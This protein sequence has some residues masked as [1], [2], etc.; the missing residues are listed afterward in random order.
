MSITVRRRGMP[1]R[2]PEAQLHLW[3]LISPALPIG[4]YAYS[5]GLE[6]AVE[7]GWVRNEADTEDWILGQ[8]QHGL[9]ALDVPVLARLYRAWATD[10][11]DAVRRWCR[12]AQAARESAELLAQER[13]LG[14][15]LQR[16]LVD[17][18]IGAARTD[19]DEPVS[20]L[21]MFAL[22]AVHW[23][24]PLPDAAAG[25]LWAWS[26]AQVAAAI[27][28]VP[29]GQTAG[30]R[31]LGAAIKVIPTAVVRGIDVL[32]DDDIGAGAPGVGLAAARHE[33]QYSRLFRS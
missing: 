13:Q 8:L 33:T 11:R 20:Q 15:A 17:L 26:E 2:M 3:R 14:G 22:A 27:K 30:Q 29:L 21:R 12:F 32:A 25:Y 16:L 4:A 28:L 10:D 5:Q 9:S 19:A 23:S 1:T 6:Y 31:I 7:S 18:G 24:I